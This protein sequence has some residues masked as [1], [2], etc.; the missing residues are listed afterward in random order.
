[1][2][3]KQYVNAI[4]K[5]IKCSGIRKK[6]IKKQLL[7]DICTRVK[8][9]EKLDVIISQMGTAKEIAD[10]FNES[11]SPEEKKRYM[12]NKVL[13]IVVPIV[14][15]MIFLVLYVYWI[16]PK[17]VDIEQSKYFNK[18]QVETA[19]KDT[20]ELLDAED[21]SA[22]QE[23]A[24]PQMQT[25][26]SAETMEDAKEALSDDWGERKQFGAVY[27]AE[28]IQ[29]NKHFAI[30]EVTVTYENVSATY[31]LTYDE[32]MRLAGIYVR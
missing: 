32:D 6:E 27:M 10:G 4:V 28:V 14:I 8:Q 17:S 11:I 15:V 16:F 31:R 2:N 22:L 18:E 25:V 9:G 20:V 3:E 5:K 12:R 19:M 1:M 30:G 24:I 26:L 29:G 13:K 23:S 21:Y 7:T